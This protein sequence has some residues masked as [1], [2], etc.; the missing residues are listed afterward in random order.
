MTSDDTTRADSGGRQWLGVIAA[1][2]GMFL[3]SLDMTVNVALPDITRSLG[4]DAQTVQWIIICYVGSSAG[5][6][7]SL[8][9]AA[10]RYGL[11]RFHLIG[12][13]IYA[14]AVLL[15]GLAPRLSMVPALRVLQVVGSGLI[16]VSAPMRDSWKSL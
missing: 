15:I 3:S 9:N 7:R 4:I 1:S 11:K 10:D 8:G 12:P 5:L 16:M 2:L 14:L 6:Q 13:G